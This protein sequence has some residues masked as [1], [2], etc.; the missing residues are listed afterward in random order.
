MIAT[1]AEGHRICGENLLAA[2]QEAREKLAGVAGELALDFSSVRRI[3]ASAVQALKEL[4]GAAQGKA[5]RVV[6]HGVDDDVYKVLKLVGL[7]TKFDF[8]V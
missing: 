3:D 5:V 2:L 8:A 6:L 4:A 1:N 7:T